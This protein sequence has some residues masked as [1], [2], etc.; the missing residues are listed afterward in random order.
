M[1][2]G[3]VSLMI[4]FPCH[5]RGGLSKGSRVEIEREADM[6]RL[7]LDGNPPVEITL[8]RNARARRLSLRVSRLDGRATLT[9][10]R[11]VSE[12][13]GLAFLRE[14]EAWLRDHLDQ[15]APELRPQIGGTLPF[16]GEDVPIA[17]AAV[18]SP[19]LEAGQLLVPEDPD[20]LGARLVAFL[21]V[22]ARDRLAEAVRRHATALGRP[23]GRLTLRDTR[24]RWG[25]CSSRGDLM[26]SWRLIMAP[27]QVLDYVAAHEVAHLAHMDHSPAFWACVERLFPDHKACRH[28]LRDE[29]TR[30]HRVRFD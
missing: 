11:R 4:A 23:H 22:Q 1:P 13:E 30:L 14:R 3:Q 16:E 5:R 10:P 8:R 15:I 7:V 18:R 24:S 6:G 27:P 17:A 9:L 20:R 19:R 28:W 29:G 12:R 25:S 2:G 21:K 26:F